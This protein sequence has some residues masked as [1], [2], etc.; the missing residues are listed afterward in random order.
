M[1]LHFVASWASAI[2]DPH[3]SE[4][5]R[6]ADGVGTGVRIVDI[7]NEPALAIAYAVPNVPAVS[8]EGR[9]G[10]L[11]VGAVPAERLV[12]VLGADT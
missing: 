4:V 7:D 8:I 12:E 10:S 1:L 2:C 5:A 6:A 11:V 3:R 9:P